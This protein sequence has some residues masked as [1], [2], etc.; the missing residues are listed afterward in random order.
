[1]AGEFRAEDWDRYRMDTR[2]P[3][4]E[5][6]PLANEIAVVNA[7]AVEFAADY[8]QP[9]DLLYLDANGALCVGYRYALRCGQPRVLPRNPSHQKQ[10]S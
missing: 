10:G 7:D 5:L 3:F 2:D 6:E 8:P 9:I 1:M 4:V